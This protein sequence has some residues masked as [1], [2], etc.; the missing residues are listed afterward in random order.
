MLADSKSSLK[1]LVKRQ[2]VKAFF[3][4][5]SVRFEIVWVWMRES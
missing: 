5:K 2:I 1:A 3:S 4:I